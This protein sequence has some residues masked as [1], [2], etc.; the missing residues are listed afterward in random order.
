MIEFLDKLKECG[1]KYA[2]YSGISISPFELGKLVT[3]EKDLAQAE[4]KVSQI[5]DHYFQG[6]YHEEESQQKKIAVWEECKDNL[7]KQLVGNMEKKS[8]SSFYHIWDSGAR[9]SSENLTQLFAMR[10]L[11]T[12]YLGEIMETP[13]TSSL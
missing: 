12:N 1:F 11:T 3:K 4:K 8:D 6:F 10:G 13:I 5:E 2:T 7:Q 9:A